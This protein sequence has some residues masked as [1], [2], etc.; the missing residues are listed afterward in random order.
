MVRVPFV[1]G[2]ALALTCCSYGSRPVITSA[3]P[4]GIVYRVAAD[5]INQ[6]RKLASR[7]CAD[8]KKTARIEQ[9]TEGDNQTVVASFRC[10]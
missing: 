5:H 8:H 10:V 7:H 1:V 2:A 9:V 3:A 6:T 4:S